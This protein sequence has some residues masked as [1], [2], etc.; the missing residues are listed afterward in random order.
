[1]R[2]YQATV[3]LR[4][5]VEEKKEAAKSRL[6]KKELSAAAVDFLGAIRCFLHYR[7]A[8]TTTR[9]PTNCSSRSRARTGVGDSVARTA[10]GV[11]AVYFAT[12]EH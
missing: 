7:N 9:L 8:R 11:D 2:D 3:W 4:Q 10:F 6:R 5:I 1:M 12:L